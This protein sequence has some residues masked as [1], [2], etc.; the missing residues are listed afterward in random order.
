MRRRTCALI[1]LAAAV[2]LAGG[3]G[4]AWWAA[5]RLTGDVHRGGALPFT[6]TSESTSG[7]PS[8]GK[9]GG[10]GGAFGPAWPVYGRTMTRTRDAADLTAIR[11]P[12]HVVWR[13]KTGFLEYPP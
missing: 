6:F 7:P 5:H 12:Y 13:D 2:L 8:S 9:D 1:A 10:H 11:P 3:A 4:A